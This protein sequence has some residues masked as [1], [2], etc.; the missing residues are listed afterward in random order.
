MN[1]LK[2]K[3][4]AKMKLAYIAHPISGDV[5]GNLE[6][7]TEI[8]RHINLTLAHIVPLVPYYAD[9]L[10]MD[11]SDER[12]RSR[13]LANGRAVLRSGLVDY[14]W[15]YGPQISRGMRGEME[16]AREAGIMILPMSRGTQIDFDLMQ[17]RGEI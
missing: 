14:L 16:E 13:G 10:A 5:D 15:L 2:R 6:R 17:Q 7:I 11:D 4:S 1:K 12:E 8:V 9:C 3:E